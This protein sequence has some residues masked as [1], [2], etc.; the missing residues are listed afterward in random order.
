MT[1][2]D[3]KQHKRKERER[4]LRREKHERLYEPSPEKREPRNRK[5]EFVDVPLARTAQEGRAATASRL[6]MERHLRSI[7]RLFRKRRVETIEEANA[8]LAARRGKTIDDVLAE[9]PPDT[10]D[11]KAQEL[12][13]RAMELDDPDVAQAL[14]RAALAIDPDCADALS[15]LAALPGLTVDERIANLRA[16]VK[17]GERSLGE[18]YFEENRGHFWGQVRSRPYMRVRRE[19]AA[20]LAAAK[21]HREAID[22]F[23]ELLG[24]NPGDNQ[25]IRYELVAAYLAAGDVAGSRRVFDRF[26]EEGLS[27][28]NWAR[29]LERFLSAVPEGARVALQKARRQNPYVERFLTGEWAIPAEQPAAYQPGH[30][31]EAVVCAMTLANAWL[32]HPTAIAWL[33]GQ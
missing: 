11:E 25:G 31:S 10:P 2:R 14:A 15:V 1:P 21:R 7:D 30:E 24:L 16:A 3:R 9:Q 23:E 18:A 28:F 29:V 26:P 4:R 17:A 22:Q 27:F 6:D 12:A 20:C 32:A 8:L 5:P 33:R 19:L 13:Y